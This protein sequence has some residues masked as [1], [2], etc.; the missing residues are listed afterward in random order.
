MVP[1]AHRPAFFYSLENEGVNRENLA[2][3]GRARP[4][5]G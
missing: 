3:I 2:E 5:A 1:A 4:M